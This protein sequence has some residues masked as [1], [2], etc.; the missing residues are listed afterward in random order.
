MRYQYSSKPLEEWTKQ[1]QRLHF[2]RAML[3]NSPEL[4][5]A[6]MAAGLH[7]KEHELVAYLVGAA[8]LPFDVS[9]GIGPWMSRRTGNALTKDGY[10]ISPQE[11]EFGLTHSLKLAAGVPVTA[12][13]YV[14][15]VH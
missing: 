9:E 2:L 6:T 7:I 12:D 3:N 15:T 10:L 5:E 8:A 11:I 13:P 14:D 1:E 4:S